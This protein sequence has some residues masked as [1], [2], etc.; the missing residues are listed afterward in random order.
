MFICHEDTVKSALASI[1][2]H[3]Q[4]DGV[5][6]TNK[7]H[8]LTLKIHWRYILIEGDFFQWTCRVH[9]PEGDLFY[10]RCLDTILTELASQLPFVLF[11]ILQAKLTELKK[12]VV[13]AIRL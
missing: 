5:S 10:S 7:I 13:R 2:N 6:Y 4:G 9:L 3:T 12:T 1:S 11:R 8:D